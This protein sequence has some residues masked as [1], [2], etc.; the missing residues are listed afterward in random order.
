M[1]KEQIVAWARETIGTPYAHQ[2]RLNGVAVDCA[3]VPAYVATKLGISFDDPANYGRVP[4]PKK[5]RAEVD[6]RLIRVTKETMQPGDV[7]WIRFK[8]EPT[9]FA[10]VGD[11]KYG[12][13]SL[14]HATNGSDLNKVVEHRL[15]KAW[16]DRIVAVWR[17]PGVEA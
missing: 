10:I 12:G 14:I 13:L 4:V 9:H 15:D 17:F 5:M 16:L 7:V 1:H 11:Y 8:A 6:K 2:Q 3:G